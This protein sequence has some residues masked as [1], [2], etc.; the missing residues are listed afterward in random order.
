[1]V[2][3]PRSHVNLLLFPLNKM[4]SVIRLGAM[5]VLMKPYESLVLPVLPVRWQ[6]PFLSG[7][8]YCTEAT[9][10]LQGLVAEHVVVSAVHHGDS[11]NEAYVRGLPLSTQRL[12]DEALRAGGVDADAISICH[13]EPGAWHLPPSLPQRWSTSI[14]PHAG[15]PFTVGRTMFETDRLPAGWSERLNALDAVWVPTRFAYDVFV[16]GGVEVSKLAV[17][18]EAV[19]TFVFTPQAQ[20]STLLPARYCPAGTLPGST[21]GCPYRFLFVGKWERRKGLDVL[22]RAFLSEFRGQS[23]EAAVE[24]F[25]LTSAYHSTA[26][27]DAAVDTMVRRELTCPPNVTE[28]EIQSRAASCVLPSAT[29]RKRRRGSLGGGLPAV[30]LLHDVAGVE[31]PGVYTAVDA[32]VLPTRGEGWGRPHVEAMAAGLPVIATNWSGPTAFLN[33]AVGYP[34][35]YTH[36]APIP[37]GPFAGHLQAEP[38]T[39]HLRELLRRLVSDPAEG[40]ARGARARASMVAS[41][42]PVH[43]AVAVRRELEKATRAVLARPRP[44]LT[45]GMRSLQDDRS[46]VASAVGDPDGVVADSPAEQQPRLDEL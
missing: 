46:R 16:A 15:A 10:I 31:L 45:R 25:I 28:A 23:T 5:F 22:L 24:L 4:R 8:G 32:A 35:A 13:S 3:V 18:P 14:C 12:L 33:E 26:D 38:D 37:D 30:R 43:V 19:D 11:Y 42:Q 34:L 6:A 29:S 40:R 9:S 44:A 1:M 7:G 21:P 17:I 36:L 2:W 20:P 41:F 39:A 27:L